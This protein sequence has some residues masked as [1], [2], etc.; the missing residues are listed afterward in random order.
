VHGEEHFSRIRGEHKDIEICD[1]KLLY[2]TQKSTIGGIGQFTKS[3]LVV[4]FCREQNGR[5]GFNS[6]SK[7]FFDKEITGAKFN[8]PLTF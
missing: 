5:S 8:L 2:D 1:S 6:E 7:G 3:L 4:P